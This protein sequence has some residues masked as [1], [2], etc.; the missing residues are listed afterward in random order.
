IRAT[1][2]MLIAVKDVTGRVVRLRVRPDGDA[3]RADGKYRW[4]SSP[5]RDGGVG[6]G[7]PVHIARPSGASSQ[8]VR[9]GITEGEL[10]G[11]A[12]SDRLG[13]TFVCIP[14]ATITAGVIPALRQMGAT[15]VA[16]FFD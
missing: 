4:V 9:S 12:A 3:T 16:T 13:M 14:G 10:K 1:A 7:A 15:E 8:A 11:N 2:G 5:D 6:S